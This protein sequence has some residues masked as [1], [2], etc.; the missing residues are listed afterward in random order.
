M[1]FAKTINKIRTEA[2]MTQ[3]QFSEIFGVSQQAV[4][5]WESGQTSP[6]LDKIIMISNESDK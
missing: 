6:D 3:E 5:K 4:Q 2:K 1:L